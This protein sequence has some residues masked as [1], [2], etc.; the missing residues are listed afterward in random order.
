ME[1]KCCLPK[2]LLSLSILDSLLHLYEQCDSG[3]FIR[4]SSFLLHFV[5]LFIYFCACVFFNY[6][7]IIEVSHLLHLGKKT[8]TNLIK[9]CIS[10]HSWNWIMFEVGEIANWQHVFFIT[11][12]LSVSFL[13]WEHLTKFPCNLVFYRSFLHFAN[14]TL[15]ILWVKRKSFSISYI[16]WKC[17]PEC[18]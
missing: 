4:F 12:L 7:V 3:D 9:S 14:L 18:Y 17:G 2:A 8:K 1:I 15:I 16:R 5:H 11:P 13:S 6:N 10:F